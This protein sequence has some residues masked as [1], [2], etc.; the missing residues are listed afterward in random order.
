LIGNAAAALLHDPEQFEHVRRHPALIPAF[1]EEALRY[2][3]PAQNLLRR[4]TRETEL[5]GVVIPEGALVMVLLGSANRDETYFS[6]ADRFNVGRSPNDHVAF[7]VGPHFCLGARLARI[8]AR[9]AFE[10]LLGSVP[11]SAT[12]STNEIP[13]FRNSN[14]IRGLE[15]LRVTSRS[16]DRNG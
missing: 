1:I 15:R 12:L 16:G 3:T 5:G 10:E 11:E 13:V 4:T 8:E 6:E 9:I 7:G 14:R 2:D